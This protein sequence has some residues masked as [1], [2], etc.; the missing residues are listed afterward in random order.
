VLWVETG[1]VVSTHSGPGA[2]GVVGFTQK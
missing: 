1:C 2:F